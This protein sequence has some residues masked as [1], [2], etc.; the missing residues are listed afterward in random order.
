M[1]M[2]HSLRIADSFSGPKNAYR[3]LLVCCVLGAQFGAS[4]AQADDGEYQVYG[5]AVSGLTLGLDSTYEAMFLAGFANGLTEQLDLITELS[6]RS[7]TES[8]DPKY[9]LTAGLSAKLDVLV[10]VPFVGIT[11]G[12]ETDGNKLGALLRLSG[13]LDYFISRSIS[14]ALVYHARL[15]DVFERDSRPSHWL[16]LRLGFH[17]EW[18]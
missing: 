6:V 10:V 7:P 14:V 8:L 16:G 11:G 12:F 3:I 4:T 9:S 18:L 17:G 15:L 5:S 2:P 13:G 1:Q